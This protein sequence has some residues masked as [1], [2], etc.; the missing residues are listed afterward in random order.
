[1]LKSFA[2]LARKMDRKVTALQ[3]EVIAAE[4]KTLDVA[5]SAFVKLSSGTMT[6]RQRRM[7]GY[8]YSRKNPNGGV[9]PA[10]I[11][12]LTGNFRRGWVKTA[13][14]LRNG[15]ISS[16]VVN[17]SKEADYMFGT[18]R[19]VQRPIDAKVASAIK[20]IRLTNLRNAIVRGLRA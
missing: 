14:R 19:M 9:D 17:R 10:Y 18:R 11:N 13:P 4:R 8:P 3:R 16:S 20:S 15:M 5:Q 1:M 6:G 12:S 2:E 7:L